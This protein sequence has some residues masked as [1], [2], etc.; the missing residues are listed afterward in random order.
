MPFLLLYILFSSTTRW[1][2]AEFSTSGRL[3]LEQMSQ[4]TIDLG[5]YTRLA[6]QS[7]V[8]HGRRSKSVAD[9]TC[10][11]H[12]LWVSSLSVLSILG[13]AQNRRLILS[14]PTSS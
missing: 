13:A 11:S 5:F 6:I 8:I 12:S 4:Q 7:C 1:T 3:E 2:I 9:P 14:R 10:K